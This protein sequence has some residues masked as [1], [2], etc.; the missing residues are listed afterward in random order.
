MFSLLAKEPKKKHLM[1]LLHS[2]NY[3]WDIIGVQLAVQYG[4]IM[5]II[6]AGG[7]LP[8]DNTRKLYQV[9]QVWI[10]KKTCEYSWRMIITVTNNPPV[11]AKRVANE[12]CKFL[13]RPE[14]MNEYC[15]S[16]KPG[17]LKLL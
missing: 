16:D 4:D 3:K 14:T 13:A 10:N 15:P 12:I 8:Y 5:N 9:L 17:K 2:I 11:E 7:N 1:T 6:S